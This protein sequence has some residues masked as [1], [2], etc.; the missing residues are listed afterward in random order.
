MINMYVSIADFL[1][2]KLGSNQHALL[3][4]GD[5]KIKSMSIVF[6]KSNDLLECFTHSL[7]DRISIISILY[8]F[9]KVL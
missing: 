2:D 8:S 3:T 5:S 4:E 6:G 7:I 1:F 9:L